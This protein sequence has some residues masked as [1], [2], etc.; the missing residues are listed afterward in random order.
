[1]ASESLRGQRA[2]QPIMHPLSCLKCELMRRIL[3]DQLDQIDMSVP[4]LFAYPA[5]SNY[6][7]VQHDLN[8]IAEAQKRGWHVLLDAAA[9]VPTNRLDLS[10]HH[11]DFV[12]LSFYKIFGIPPE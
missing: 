8:W 7:G 5:Q 12:S 4:N 6:T 1:M 9:F 2:Q 10:V 3:A 11:P